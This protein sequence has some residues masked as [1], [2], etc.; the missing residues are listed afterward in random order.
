MLQLS[1]KDVGTIPEKDGRN[2]SKDVDDF[3]SHLETDV[4][5]KDHYQRQV[6]PIQT[7]KTRG[8]LNILSL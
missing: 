4:P 2:Y 7:N 1:D 5:E 8:E 6:D 3:G